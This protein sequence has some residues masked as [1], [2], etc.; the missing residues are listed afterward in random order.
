M[1]SGVSGVPVWGDVVELPVV[2]GDVSTVVEVV[3][4]TIVV[5]GVAAVVVVVAAPSNPSACTPTGLT[6]A[7][8]SMVTVTARN[9]IK[10]LRVL[11][12]CEVLRCIGF[13]PAGY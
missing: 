4:V 2:G 1:A 3:E 11:T 7:P 6:N 12:R 13:S 9:H 10:P 5:G 8:M